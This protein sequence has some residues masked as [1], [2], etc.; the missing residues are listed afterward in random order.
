MAFWGEEGVRVR[1]CDGD[2]HAY[3]CPSCIFF[4]IYTIFFI[5]DIEISV[6]DILPFIYCVHIIYFCHFCLV[7][8]F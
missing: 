8:T 1:V 4:L 5:S 3:L 7:Y 2:G 6:A